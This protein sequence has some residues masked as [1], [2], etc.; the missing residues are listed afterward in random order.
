M[1]YFS[2]VFMNILKHQRIGVKNVRWRARNL[3]GFIKDIFIWIKVLW[4]SIITEFLIF[5]WTICRQSLSLM[6]TLIE[7]N[8]L[9]VTLNALTLQVFPLRNKN[10]LFERLTLNVNQ[11]CRVLFLMLREKW[12]LFV[13]FC[14]STS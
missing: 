4:E 8:W 12:L 14:F 2:D 9:S 13:L 7:N 1:D 6:P 11:W 3:S 5:G 10:T